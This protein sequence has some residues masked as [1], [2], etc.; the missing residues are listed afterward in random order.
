MYQL[1]CRRAIGRTESQ[2]FHAF[3]PAQVIVEQFFYLSASY[4]IYTN[5]RTTIPGGPDQ[6]L[7]FPTIFDLNTDTTRVEFLSS[8]DGQTWHRV[9]GGPV[10]KT[11]TYG[12]WDGGCVF[13]SPNLVEL[14]DGG[15]WVLPYTGYAD[16]HKYPH[17]GAKYGVGLAVWPKGRLCAIAADDEGSFTTPPLLVPGN[18]LSINAVTGRNG[19]VLAEA[20]D[21]TGKPIEGRTF[22]DAAAGLGDLH[23]SPVTWKQHADLGTKP[24]EPVV[25]R[26][27]MKLARIY[28]LQFK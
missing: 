23:W 18:T 26:F 11:A 27:R 4:E 21:A 16:P 6:H 24:G 7:M 14:P 1:Y 28:G 8:Y 10:L 19:F 12:Q 15:G 17:G 9:P 13:A 25:L 20:A 5:C 2:D 3:A 22:A